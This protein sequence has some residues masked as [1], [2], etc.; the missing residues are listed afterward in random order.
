MAPFEGGELALVG[1]T[2]QGYMLTALKRYGKTP[3]WFLNTSPIFGA[4]RLPK[5]HPSATSESS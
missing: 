3:H 5:K 4:V 1:G 2:L